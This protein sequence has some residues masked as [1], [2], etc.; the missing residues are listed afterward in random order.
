MNT[1]IHTLLLVGVLGFTGCQ[2]PNTKQAPNTAVDG[3]ARCG[4][5]GLRWTAPD[6]LRIAYRH[7]PAQGR[8]RGV[9]AAMPGW[10]SDACDW[11]PLARGL[12]ARGYEIYVTGRRSQWGDPRVYRGDDLKK[13]T[14]GDLHDWQVWPKDYAA[15]TRWVAARHPGRPLIYA[16][17]SMGSEEVLN[18]AGNPEWQGAPARGVFV[19]SPPL[20][21]MYPNAS[22]GFVTAFGPLF[23]DQDFRVADVDQ[24]RADHVQLMNS[25]TEWQRW[26]HS[27]DRVREGFTTRWLG[28]AAH[29]GS[30]AGNA[31][32]NIHGPV[33][34]YLGGKDQLL[35]ENASRTAS[36]AWKQCQRDLSHARV[37]TCVLPNGNHLPFPDS[38][39]GTQVQ[40]S[41]ARWLDRVSAANQK[42][43]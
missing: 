35:A 2:L 33:F 26:S 19:I 31:A 17:Q 10:D 8:V 20:P 4:Q 15:F 13:A 16:G 22:A 7:W 32:K 28:E 1:R 37:T 23:L 34:I 39:E 27:S 12:A 40:A 42:S 43:N 30:S 18:V 41:V 29:M 5:R 38:P 14:R 24:M 21:F 25:P 11:A 36:D 3:P 9:I 6:G